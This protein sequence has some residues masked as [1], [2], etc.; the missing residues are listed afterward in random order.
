M[1]D[2]MYDH[3]LG[4]QYRI[5]KRGFLFQMELNIGP[6]N[7]K[8]NPYFGHEEFNELEVNRSN[9]EKLINVWITHGLPTYKPD[10]DIIQL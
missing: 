9:I 6:R 5:S 8:R 2:H 4:L 3:Y 10:P 1:T 7:K